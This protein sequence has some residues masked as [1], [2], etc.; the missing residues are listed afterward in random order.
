ME[1]LPPPR[2]AHGGLRLAP[3]GSQKP[4]FSLD[5]RTATE[6]RPI[7]AHHL[8]CFFSFLHGLV[9]F[10]PFQRLL[11]SVFRLAFLPGLPLDDDASQTT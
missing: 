6:A 4:R 3:V 5:G 7:P 2:N 11:F 9:Y 10:L 1:Q 8:F